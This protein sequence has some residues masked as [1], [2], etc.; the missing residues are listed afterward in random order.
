M[1]NARESF[2]HAQT[3]CVNEALPSPTWKN[4]CEMLIT[5]L[6]DFRVLTT[7]CSVAY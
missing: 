2:A 4:L 5:V 1:I 3:A 6:L 7:S